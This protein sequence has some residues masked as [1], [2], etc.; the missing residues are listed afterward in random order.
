MIRSSLARRISPFKVPSQLA[1]RAR[2][3]QTTTSVSRDFG[4][5]FQFVSTHHQ[6]RVHRLVA[7]TR[8]PST[9]PIAPNLHTTENV[10][11][12]ELPTINPAKLDLG[13]ISVI[14][15]LAFFLPHFRIEGKKYSEST[16]LPS[17]S[18]EG[19][20]PNVRG[21]E[22]K[23]HGSPP[24]LLVSK[25]DALWP[26][27]QPPLNFAFPESL[28]LP[29]E[30]RPYQI[31]G[32]RFLADNESALLGDDMGT[33][34]TV[35]ATV[36]LRILAQKGKLRK[37]LIVCPLAV[38][39]S[40][41]DHT[42][43][44][45]RVLNCVK[46]RGNR[47]ERQI[48]WKTPAHVYLATYDTVREDVHSLMS[49]DGPPEF[50]LIVADEVQKIKNSA[51]STSQ[52]MRAITSP[53]RWGLSATPFE[54]RAEE[55]VS[56]F[57]FIKP[58]LLFHDRETPKSIREKITP[59][60]LRR[61]KEVLKNELPEKVQ[62]VIW[63]ELGPNQRRAYDLAEKQGI[64][65][66]EKQ[67]EKVT[68]THVLALLLKLKQLC[69]FDPRTGES[70]KLDTLKEQLQEVVDQ[71]S[72]ALVFSQFKD[73]NFGVLKIRNALNQQGILQYTG[74]LTYSERERVL[75]QLKSDPSSKV[76]LCTQAAAGLGLNL[77]AANYVFHFDHWWNDAR[78]IQAE[79]RVHRIGQTKTVFVYHFW[80]KRTVEERILRILERKRAQ[81]EEV[82]GRI[83]NMEGTGLSEDELFEIF[84]LKKGAKP[85]IKIRTRETQAPETI[86]PPPP[87]TEIPEM[88]VWPLIR[89]TELALRKCIREVLV[90]LYGPRTQARVLEH[91]GTDEAE[92]INQTIDQY[93]R[94]YSTSPDEFSASEDP[95]DYTYLKQ[96]MTVIS[97]EWQNFKPIFGDRG[98]VDSKLNEIAAVRNDEA[99]FRNIPPIEKMRAY[100]ACA[101]LLAR[102]QPRRPTTAS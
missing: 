59:Y 9:L 40:W 47:K 39:S 72:K 46:I 63:L 35:Q 98:F 61:T 90:P 64:I 37:A 1:L 30:L 77:V 32:V 58:K 99:H 45:G 44:W 3:I 22:Q 5:D 34:K 33:G 16:A 4:P 73:D 87:I 76:M 80:V 56:V 69:N 11:L 13:Q 48:Q 100:V 92:R 14:S 51:T 18:T 17:R 78:T 42:H 55:L 68:V 21:N 57:A 53:R 20:A 66:L 54:N 81:F 36:A 12:T 49:E 83:S 31:D 7:E 85:T 95:L 65:E 62:D 10:I 93:K 52:A 25:W 43:N 6:L 101:D 89:K 15:R 71:G 79:D 24:P 60:F 23:R 94:K 86:Q 50:D 26:L 38:L 97:R 19:K 28:D 27:L 96:M 75:D 2:E 70:I 41:E 8:N 91:L 84:G 82:I 67:G 88:D 74:D 102:L 29:S